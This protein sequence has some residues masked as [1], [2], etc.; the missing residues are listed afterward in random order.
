MS[1]HPDGRVAVKVSA[2]FPLKTNPAP[3]SASVM[4]KINEIIAVFRM[5]SPFAYLRTSKSINLHCEKCQTACQAMRK[6][7]DCFHLGAEEY[8]TVAGQPVLP[9]PS[10]DFEDRKNTPQRITTTL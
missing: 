8:F 3:T 6:L 7:D 1:S 2:V 4:I 10:P 5:I 9:Q